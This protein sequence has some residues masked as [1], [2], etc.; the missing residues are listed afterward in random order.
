M[1][2]TSYQKN[3]RLL[4]EVRHQLR[5]VCTEPDSTEAKKII[6]NHWYLNAMEKSLMAGSY[7]SAMKQVGLGLSQFVSEHYKEEQ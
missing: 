3:K 5:I 6:I 2:E 4:K 7:F 1:K